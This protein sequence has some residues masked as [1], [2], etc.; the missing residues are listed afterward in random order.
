MSGH[1]ENPSYKIGRLTGSEHHFQR[2]LNRARSA[3]LVLWIQTI[4]LRISAR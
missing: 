2:K 3:D 4:A 1:L